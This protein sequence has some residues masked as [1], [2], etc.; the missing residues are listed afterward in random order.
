M[1]TLVDGSTIEGVYLY[2]DND[3]VFF[4]VGD[5]LLEIP[6]NEIKILTLS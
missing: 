1:I 6:M 4:E 2:T 5:A 3:I